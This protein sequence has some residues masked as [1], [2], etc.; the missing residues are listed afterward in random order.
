MWDFHS[1][2]VCVH[3][4]EHLIGRNF[5]YTL[6]FPRRHFKCVYLIKVFFFFFNFEKYT[7]IHMALKL[8]VLKFCLL[9]CKR[10][11][12]KKHCCSVNLKN[13]QLVQL[14]TATAAKRLERKFMFYFS[15]TINEHLALTPQWQYWKFSL[16]RL[17]PSY[18]YM[19]EKSFPAMTCPT[20][21]WIICFCYMT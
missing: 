14:G 21:D 1:I 10:K 8:K 6:I 16:I 2:S 3:F 5:V 19:C 20:W 13:I 17:S 4:R 9:W 12:K 11:K 18:H 15:I 7:S